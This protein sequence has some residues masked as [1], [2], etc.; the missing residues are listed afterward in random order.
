MSIQ[1]SAVPNFFQEYSKE[2][3][4][5]FERIT[6][7][8]H[9]SEMVFYERLPQG[10]LIHI[11]SVNIGITPIAPRAA[12]DIRRYFREKDGTGF[13]NSLLKLAGYRR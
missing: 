9:G 13:L 10:G 11:T 12:P 6:M 3:G 2:L 5:Y 7:E 1:T 8:Q 4:T